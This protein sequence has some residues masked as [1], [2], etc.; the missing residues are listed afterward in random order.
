MR[1]HGVSID[2]TKYMNDVE[3][4]KAIEYGAYSS[5]VKE[6]DFFRKELA[7]KIRAGNISIL[8]L[9]YIKDLQGLWILLLAAITQVGRNPR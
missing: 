9:E 4:K 1:E 2:M 7:N 6:K 5:V 3:I 8:T